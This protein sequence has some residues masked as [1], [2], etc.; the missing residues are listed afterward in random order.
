MF[1]N[2]LLNEEDSLGRQFLDHMN[3]KGVPYQFYQNVYHPTYVNILNIIKMSFGLVREG[4][5]R[6]GP[7][8]Q[9][10]EFSSLSNFAGN[11]EN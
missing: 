5:P 10:L 7:D 1:K 9:L 11:G 2:I 6:H 4:L 8:W 3:F